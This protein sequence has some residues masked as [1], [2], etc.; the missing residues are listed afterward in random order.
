MTFSI[1]DIQ[2]NNDAECRILFMIMLNGI[3]LSVIIQNVVMLS[4][5]ALKKLLLGEGQED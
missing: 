2:Y 3:M 5:M 1:R 4:V